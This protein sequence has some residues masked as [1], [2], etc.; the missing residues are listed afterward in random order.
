MG[1]HQNPLQRAEV[2]ILA[3]MGA[4]LDSTLDA[5]VCM[6][7]HSADPPYRRDGLRLPQ[8]WENIHFRYGYD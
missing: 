4:L 2:S 7:I 1:A 3:V 6:T 5:L 8:V